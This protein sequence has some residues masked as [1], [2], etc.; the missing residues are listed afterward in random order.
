MIWQT[1]LCFEWF[2]LIYSGRVS[3]VVLLWGLASSIFKASSCLLYFFS[4]EWLNSDLIVFYMPYLKAH[5]SS[6]IF[7]YM[8]SNW[9]LKRLLPFSSIESYHQSYTQFSFFVLFVAMVCFIPRGR[10]VV[11]TI[12]YPSSIWTTMFHHDTHIY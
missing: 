3:A 12:S 10:S 7:I 2:C 9:F 6:Q 4:R 11:R 8:Y 1:K 5:C